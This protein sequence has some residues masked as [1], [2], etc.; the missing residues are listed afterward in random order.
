MFEFPQEI[1]REFILKKITQETIMEHYLGVNI[2]TKTFC[3]PLRNDKHPSCSFY[4]NNIGNVYMIDYTGFFHGDCFDVV[5]FKYNCSFGEALHIIATDFGLIKAD[6]VVNPPAIVYSNKIMESVNKETVLQATIKDFTEEELN[7]WAKFGITKKILNKYRVFSIHYVFI[8]RVPKLE[9]TAASPIYGYYYGKD[10]TGRELWKFYM[11]KKKKFRFLMNTQKMQGTHMLPKTGDLLVVTKSMKDV[12]VFHSMGIPAIAPQSESVILTD[13]DYN[14]YKARFKNI[15]V[16]YDGD[17]AG[18][19]SMLKCR[20]KYPVI[21]LLCSNKP[22]E[23]AKDISDCVIKYGFSKVMGKVVTLRERINNGEFN[24]KIKWQDPE[25][26][27]Q[28]MLGSLK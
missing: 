5:K 26:K 24:Y 7:W 6:R 8:N 1:S 20:K 28:E 11:P 12:M 25:T 15:V 23:E 10:T 19:N 18:I 13:S 9:S 16:V 21:C 4:K 14:K 27:E 3:N 22:K 2:N 17:R